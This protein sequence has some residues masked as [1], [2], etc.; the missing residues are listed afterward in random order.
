MTLAVEL[1]AAVSD[2]VGK[3]LRASIRRSGGD[4]SCPLLSSGVRDV[5]RTPAVRGER[6]DGS[7]ERLRQR[8][9]AMPRPLLRLVRLAQLRLAVRRDLDAVVQGDEVQPLVLEQ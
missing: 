8:A 2:A 4:S 6:C 3:P 9:P 7:E 1:T 5:L